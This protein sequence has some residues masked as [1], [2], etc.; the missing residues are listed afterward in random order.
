MLSFQSSLKCYFGLHYGIWEN[1]TNQTECLRCQ[2][3]MANESSCDFPW[4]KRRLS[5]YSMICENKKLNFSKKKT[6]LSDV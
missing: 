1:H 6:Y 4:I 5:K 3:K 2:S